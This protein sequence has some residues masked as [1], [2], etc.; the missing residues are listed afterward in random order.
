M[1]LRP[2]LRL[3][4]LLV[5]RQRKDNSKIKP[6]IYHSRLNHENKII[7]EN[8]HNNDAKTI[9]INVSP[10]NFVQP[11]NIDV[12]HNNWFIN[13]SGTH[14]PD[15]VKLLLQF[16]ENFNLPI[17]NVT[18]TKYSFIKQIENNIR[19]SDEELQCTIRNI[20]VPIINEI[21]K[22]KT[23]DKNDNILLK[24]L[25]VTKKFIQENPNVFFTRADKDNITVALEKNSYISIIENMLSDQNTYKLI[26]NN[27]VQKMT[28][29]L[30]KI[31]SRWKQKDFIGDIVYKS[32][33]IN[34]GT[35]ARAYGLPKLHKSGNQYRIIISS[36]GTP[37][38]ALASFLHDKI[39]TSLTNSDRTIKNSTDLIEKI[40]NLHVN[41]NIS[42]AS[43]DVISLFTNVPLE[44]AINSIKRR[45]DIISNN[46]NIPMDEFIIAVKF[47]FESTFLQFN[48]K[49]YK[50]IY[51]T[52]MGSPLSP[53]IADIV[54]MDLE[55]KAIGVLPFSL[56]VYYRYVDDVL[57]AAPNDSFNIILNI[58][59]SFHHRLKFT[60][61]LS[62][63]NKINFLNISIII[64][65]GTFMFDL[66]QKPTFSGRFLSFYSHHHWTHKKGVIVSLI[67][68]IVNIVN[69]CWQEKNI[70]LV[71]SWLLQ[72]GYPLK[73]IFEVI[74]E[75]IK[76]HCF[77]VD[78]DGENNNEE[79]N[80]MFFVIPYVRNIS[81]KFRY[82]ID[83]VKLA[84]SCNN[85]LNKFIHA[86][87]D[88]LNNLE[89]TSVV[90]KIV[91][92]DCDAAYV[93]QT[94]RQ[95]STRVREHRSDIKKSSGNLSVISLHRINEGHEFDW[96][97][98]K[99]LDRENNLNK[100]LTSEMLYIK[101]QVNSINKQNDTELLPQCYIPF[102]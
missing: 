50:Q 42:L 59:N 87:K 44:E 8:I 12:F 23:F 76:Y 53:V 54:L 91:C 82:K 74:N 71:I 101:K 96:D 9:T 20:T 4:D 38:Y 81:D 89:M 88:K 37:L 46:T 66:Y 95:L 83:S 2:N 49:M 43:L 6:I 62:D 5:L 35:M 34:D 13:R 92:K 45:W 70:K 17:D 86:G 56:P 22:G 19:R 18:Q 98:V 1:V 33:M 72:N 84:H 61:E 10:N 90:Y 24:R 57:I 55:E 32:L 68:K 100:R 75:R 31:L 30:R 99:I 64:K 78:N 40:K 93:G 67:D 21:K 79:D 36:I 41:E 3:N 77:G 52:P 28:N 102:I 58:F 29:D 65:N 60:L 15:E 25:S 51:G 16:G 69:P 48:K 94:K 14:I 63:N 97:N 47:V 27:P 80:E 11:C 26:H 85:K 73:T 39:K 7:V